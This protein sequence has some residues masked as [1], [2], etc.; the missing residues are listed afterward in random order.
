MMGDRPVRDPDIKALDIIRADIAALIRR[1]GKGAS[2]QEKMPRQQSGLRNQLFASPLANWPDIIDAWNEDHHR[3]L[4]LTEAK[5]E[6]ARQRLV[7]GVRGWVR[8]VMRLAPRQSAPHML[9]ALNDLI[10]RDRE[11]GAMVQPPRK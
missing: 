7:Q 2:A 4:N 11:F 3:R 10:E 1:R 9:D 8:N 6:R 5:H